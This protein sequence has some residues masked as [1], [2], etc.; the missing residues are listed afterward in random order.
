MFRTCTV[1]TY[2]DTT[3]SLGLKAACLL[4]TLQHGRMV[5]YYA[6]SYNKI[7]FFAVGAEST[8]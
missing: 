5:I 8:I 1:K 3:S 7:A 2:K 6:M 4:Y